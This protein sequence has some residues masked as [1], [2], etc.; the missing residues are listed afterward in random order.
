MVTD[1]LSYH[2]Y[3]VYKPV[4]TTTLFRAYLAFV[5]VKGIA[6]GI[7]ATVLDI[8]FVRALI[9]V[10]VSAVVTGCFGIVVAIIQSKE[11][12]RVHER[13]DRLELT[14]KQI[15]QTGQ[16]IKEVVTPDPNQPHDRRKGDNPS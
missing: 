10:L 8:N 4:K 6:M 2:T 16:E 12:S 5:L 14:G 9:L 3:Y 15:E 11:N 1:A 7:A 13:L